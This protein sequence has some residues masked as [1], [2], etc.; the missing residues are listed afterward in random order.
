MGQPE[1]RTPFVLIALAWAVALLPLSWG[2][3]QS[4]VK[5]LPLFRA[6]APAGK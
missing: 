5:S 4:V 3:C 6:T 1:N 2:V